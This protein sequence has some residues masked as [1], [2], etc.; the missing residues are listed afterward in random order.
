MK[1]RGFSVFRLIVGLALL[2]I[3]A[4]G[5]WY[6]WQQMQ[7]QAG[8]GPQTRKTLNTLVD[9]FERYQRITTG[10]LPPDGTG[11]VKEFL[12]INELKPDVSALPGFDAATNTVRDGW[13]RPIEFHIRSDNTCYFS[14][15]GPDGKMGTADDLVSDKK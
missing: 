14:S 7:E 1:R 4:G 5:C 12:K 11:F 2:G 3:I 9:Q 10:S 6:I 15:A 8:P 13:G